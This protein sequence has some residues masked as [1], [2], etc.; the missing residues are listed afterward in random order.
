MPRRRRPLQRYPTIAP[1]VSSCILTTNQ[2]R[3]CAIN[4]FD[5]TAHR[6]NDGCS[7][8]QMATRRLRNKCT[9]CPTNTSC[10]PIRY[11][12]IRIVRG[13]VTATYCSIRTDSCPSP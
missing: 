8:S 6:R 12:M 10:S 13:I 2:R 9:S 4:I 5:A 1:A 11:S 7:C 3:M